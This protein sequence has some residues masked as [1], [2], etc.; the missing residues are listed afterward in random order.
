MRYF[1]TSLAKL[2]TLLMQLM[3]FA[4]IILL[5][6]G[7]LHKFQQ[8]YPTTKLQLSGKLDYLSE[9]ELA[10]KIADLLATNLWAINVNTVKDKIYQDPWVNFVFVNKRWPDI[11][12][13]EV[14]SH[15]PI[16]KWNDQFLLTATGKILSSNELE[17]LKLPKLSGT[18][19]EEKMLIDTY[20]LLLEKL[21]VVGLFVSEVICTKEQEI[22]VLL[23]N[24]V[25]LILGSYD[26]PDR[27][28]R[29][30]LSYNKKLQP[31]ISDI[32]Y[33]DLRYNNGVA[34]SWLSKDSH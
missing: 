6:I 23:D 8:Q 24:N 3:L 4:A 14:I 2:I 21:S 33:I 30:I 12:Q 29:F 27:I 19:G 16:A 25:K 22:E 15:N 5:L 1:I 32:A 34:V 18:A 9:S 26:L 31:M 17:S 28:N 11:L 13:V 7:Y 10:S 20:Y